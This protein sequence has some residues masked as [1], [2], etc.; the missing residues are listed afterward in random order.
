LF[1]YASIGHIDTTNGIGDYFSINGG[2]VS[3]HNNLGEPGGGD[4]ADWNSASIDCV[5]FAQTGMRQVF[6]GADIRV[7]EAIG[8]NT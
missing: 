1:R 2:H 7:M 8:W 3:L 5:G 6:T 4:L